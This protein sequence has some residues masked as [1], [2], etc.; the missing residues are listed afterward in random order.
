MRNRSKLFEA[1]VRVF[2]LRGNDYTK[3]LV[4]KNATEVMHD[5]WLRLGERLNKSFS[6]MGDKNS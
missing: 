6:I 3:F 5:N 4:N 2:S 1:M